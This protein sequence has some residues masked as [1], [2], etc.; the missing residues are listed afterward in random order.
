M[1]IAVLNIIFAALSIAIAVAF[2]SP[3][4]KRGGNKN[5]S[6]KKL[7]IFFV[8]F[9]FYEILL[10]YFL[11]FDNLYIA[12]WIHVLSNALIFVMLIFALSIVFKIIG[13]N[14]S[15][16]NIY[17]AI[18]MIIG[19]LAL[20]IQIYYLNAP[21]VQPD[22]YIDWNMNIVAARIVSLSVF[23]VAIFWTYSFLDNFSSFDD[24]YKKMR[25]LFLAAA[26]LFLGLSGLTTFHSYSKV[27]LSFSHSFI[28]ASLLFFILTFLVRKKSINK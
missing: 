24:G 13:L 15:S 2:L 18:T 9:A 10:A 1:I 11:F 14:K 25:V 23:M 28:F 16:K 4:I 21:I 6:L 7:S 8:L 20:G 26:G 17:Y 27:M 3:Y 22:G 12:S 5:K 19:A